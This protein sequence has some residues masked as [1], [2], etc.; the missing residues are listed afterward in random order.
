MWSQS[1][2]LRYNKDGTPI[3]IFDDTPALL[4]TTFIETQVVSSSDIAADMES[5]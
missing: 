3:T 4:K 1:L 5:D 2:E